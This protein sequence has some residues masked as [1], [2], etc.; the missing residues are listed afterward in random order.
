M[1]IWV[2]QYKGDPE[3][4]FVV[5]ASTKHEAFLQIDPLVAEPD[6]KSFKEL[7]AAGFVN[8]SATSKDS[9]TL[10]FTPPEHDVKSGFWLVFG[11]G[12]GKEEPATQHILKRISKA[13]TRTHKK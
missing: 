9:E 12:N 8:F 5:W 4:W 6:L 3:N 1:K 11:G 7:S 2:G 10:E 13:T